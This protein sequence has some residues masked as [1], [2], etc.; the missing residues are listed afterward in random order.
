MASE[1]PF[2]DEDGNVDDVGRRGL[3]DRHEDDGRREDVEVHVAGHGE[4]VGD[5][6]GHCVEWRIPQWLLR[7]DLRLAPLK[8]RL[9]SRHW[10]MKRSLEQLVP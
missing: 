7:Q 8:L 3:R 5:R 10:T 4:H 2:P 1:A 6:Q 9:K